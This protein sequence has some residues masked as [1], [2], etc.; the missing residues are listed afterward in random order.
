[1]SECVGV[2]RVFYRVMCHGADCGY[3]VLV[4]THVEEPL[5]GFVCAKGVT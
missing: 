1:M 2:E 3:F 5:W 4:V